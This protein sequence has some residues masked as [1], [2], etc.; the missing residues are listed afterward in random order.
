LAE[1][2][3]KKVIRVRKLPLTARGRTPGFHNQNLASEPPT[4]ISR[5]KK[6]SA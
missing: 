5:Y 3:M 2:R 4:M 1:T 6:E